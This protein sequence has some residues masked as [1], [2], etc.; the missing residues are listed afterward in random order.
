[1][2]KTDFLK[3]IKALPIEDL[4]KKKADLVLELSN[5]NFQGATQ[6]LQ[7]PIRKRDIRREIAR[8]NSVLVA[9]A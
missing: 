9:K 6:Q 5:L 3:E 1:M 7:N 2:K 4:N 8:I